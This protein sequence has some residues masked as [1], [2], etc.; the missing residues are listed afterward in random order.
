MRYLDNVF[1]QETT[2]GTMLQTLDKYHQIEETKNLKA[3][4]DK[5]FLFLEPAYPILRIRI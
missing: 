3:A 2:T 5:T 4:P 1:I